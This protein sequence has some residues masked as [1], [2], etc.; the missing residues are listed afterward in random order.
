MKRIAWMAMAALL[1][2]ACASS[3]THQGM[4]YRD[5]SWYAPGVDGG[6]DYYTGVAHPPPAAYDWPWAWSVG[7]TPYGGYCPVRYRYCTSWADPWYDY[8][9]Y[10]PY[11]ISWQPWHGNGHGRRH[12]E[13]ASEPDPESPLA[14]RGARP[15]RETRQR[16][17]ARLRDPAADS[18]V[19]RSGAGSSRARRRGAESGSGDGAE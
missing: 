9:F 13:P 11:G 14:E 19:R 1:L 3:G 2:G 18:G 6:G 17:P 12:R 5:G 8:G 10:R 4:V 15:P 7:F 16:P